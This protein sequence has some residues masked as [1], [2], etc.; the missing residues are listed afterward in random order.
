M[1]ATLIKHKETYETLIYNGYK[2][3]A[4]FAIMGIGGYTKPLD[5]IDSLLG[6]SRLDDDIPGFQILGKT[7]KCL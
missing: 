7:K 1:V 4:D 6:F 3:S 5:A 2:L